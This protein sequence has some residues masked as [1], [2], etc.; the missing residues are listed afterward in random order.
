MGS[1]EN[2]HLYLIFFIFI[3]FLSS[4]LLG[5]VIKPKH[6]SFTPVERLRSELDC[7]IKDEKLSSAHLGIHIESLD[8]GEVMYHHNENKLFIPASNIKLFTTAAGLIYLSPNFTYE[9]ELLTNGNI[10]SGILKGDLIII[11][12]GDPTISGYFNDGN[13][14]KVFENWADTLSYLGIKEIRGNIV[15]DNSYFDDIP[16]GEGWSWDDEIFWY[17]ARKDAFSFNDNSIDIFIYHGDSIGAPARVR[18]KPQTKYINIVNKVIT[19]NQSSEADVSFKMLYDTN[20]LEIS[21]IFPINSEEY[22]K[23]IAV[24]NPAHYGAFVFGE[25]LMR[26]GITFTGKVYIAGKEQ[27]LF[28]NRK[29]LAFYRS[30]RLD[31]IIY[32]INKKSKNLH[33]EQLLLTIGREFK[34]KGDSKTAISAIR[35]FL[36]GIGINTDNFFMVD[37][38]GLSRYNLVTPKKVVELL[39]FMARHRYFDLYYNSLPIAGID[40][41]LK[42]RMKAA[43]CKNNLRAKTGSMNHIRN[44]SGYATTKDGEMMVFSMMCNHYITPAQ[45]VDD[46]YERI[47]SRLAVFLREDR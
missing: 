28:Q 10:E 18:T 35:E 34:G 16:M 27:P 12:R 15:V 25:T 19:G 20:N 8:T 7:L 21:G 46:L 4:S 1:K 17:S 39:R 37:G 41:T 29:R 6:E 33:A 44:L 30:P 32:V 47:C 3:A 13:T 38:S 2:N 43:P 11:G 36:E 31:E 40:G 45:Y 14:T 22:G 9:T 23:S 42:N 26:K 24:K 5:C